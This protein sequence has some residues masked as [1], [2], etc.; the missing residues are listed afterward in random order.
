MKDTLGQGKS[1]G[2]DSVFL[3]TLPLKSSFLSSIKRRKSP[4]HLHDVT[5]GQFT[6]TSL[7]AADRIDSELTRL[8]S[9]PNFC[10]HLGF[11]GYWGKLQ[12]LGYRQQAQ[13]NS[14]AEESCKLILVEMYGAARNKIKASIY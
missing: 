13:I 12:Q 2:S 10:R 8:A 3:C 11:A 9:V 7:S 14:A 4:L 1:L 5:C 6:S